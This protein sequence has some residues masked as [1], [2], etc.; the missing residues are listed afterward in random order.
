MKSSHWCVIAGMI[1]LVFCLRWGMQYQLLWKVSYTRLCYNQLADN[2]LED[3]LQRGVADAATPYIDEAVAVETFED[4]LLKGFDVSRES[5]GGK[6][7]LDCIT[8]IVILQND[9]FSVITQDGSKQY[10][11]QCQY[12]DWQVTFSMDG[13]VICKR[14]G[15]NIQFQGTEAYI[16][17]IVG[18]SSQ[19]DEDWRM[20][21]ITDCVE[22]KLEVTLKEQIKDTQYIVDFPQIKE[23]AC[24][25][26][27][28]VGMLSFIQY[29]EYSMDGCDY[30]RYVFS[31]VRLVDKADKV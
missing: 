23:E 5:A 10:S 16:R 9:Y 14:I 21:V 28:G 24:H 2:A 22:E 31:G 3:A 27:D 18:Y 29:E 8:C 30:S 1:L 26:L 13:E 4:S 12:G 6:R 17:S 7:L 19:S 20:Q 11:Y 15:Y 25:T